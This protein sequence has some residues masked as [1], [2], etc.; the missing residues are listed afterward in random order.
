MVQQSTDRLHPRGSCDP[1][2]GRGRWQ[3]AANLAALDTAMLFGVGILG[4]LARYGVTNARIVGNEIVLPY[5]VLCAIFAPAWVLTLALSGA[6]G[7]REVGDGTEEYRRL[8]VGS[9]RFVAL[10]AILAFSIHLDLSRLF[11]A[12]LAPLGLA[13]VL[14]SHWMARRWLHRQRQSGRLVQRVIAVGNRA[15]V[16][17]LVRH[18]R[19]EPYVG[20]VVVAACT[21]VDEQEVVVDG[22]AI[23]VIGDPGLLVSQARALGADYLVFADT[24]VPGLPA[25]RSIGWDLEGTGIGLA[26]AP[27]VVEVAGP[28]IAIRQL[29]GLPLLVV[30]EPRLGGP[31]RAFKQ[32]LERALAAVALAVLSPVLVVIGMAT[33]LTSRGPA[34]YRQVRI[35]RNGKPFTM[36]KF[37]TMID[38]ADAQ[39]EA[40]EHLNE[41]GSPLFKIRRDP[42]VT[43]LGR[44]LRRFSLDE[45][46]QIWHVA[47]GVMSIVGPRPPLPCEIESY[48]R[49]SN[50]RLLV[51]PGLTGLW[52]VS[53]RSDLSWDESIR[54]DLYYVENWS[55]SLDLV[56]LM[57]TIVAVLRARG[58][59]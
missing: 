17:D 47:T 36:L 40:L 7:G 51:P 13:G 39:R 26:V 11:V 28:R 27:S 59:Y 3:F 9:I 56:I 42:R 20:M 2:R 41:A 52:Q 19:R 23:P 49:M 44:W 43:L 31:T 33:R 53:G 16:E 1:E 45:L 35:G 25:L 14:A 38:G 32:V 58:A 29:A 15:H 12:L 6:Y 22:L 24:K 4:L 8:V 5:A 55:L 18:L 46:P 48:D 50:R 37:R 34:L 30:E 21:S 57:K 54:L 10:L